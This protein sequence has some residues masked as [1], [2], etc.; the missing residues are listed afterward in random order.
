MQQIAKGTLIPIGGNE[1]KGAGANETET[2]E[3]I[4]E[5][6]LS[7]IVK[8]SGGPEGLFVVIP[9]ASS[10]PLEVGNSYLDAFAK[11][12]CKNV[13]VLDIRN[14]EESEDPKNIEIVKKANCI[15][16]SGGD[17]SK[18]TA[19]IGDTS[20]HSVLMDRYR[21]DS[22]FVIAGTSAGA[23]AMSQEM[24]AGGNPA[25]S[26]TKGAVRMKD[27][28]G[29]T[30]KIMFD[31]HFIQRGRFGRITQAV[32]KYPHILGIGLAENTGLVIKNEETL[33]VIGTGMVIVFDGSEINHNTE[34]DLPDG[35]PMTITN[36]KVQVLANSD[37]YNLV[38][39]EIHVLPID[40]P[41]E[42]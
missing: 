29:L 3:F 1:D 22:D 35:T 38:T 19:K 4:H 7:Q 33:K 26:F 2:L 31:T 40:A 21:N 6:I 17:Q 9:T 25:D 32:A 36:L 42:F 39:K 18:I 23:M 14:K 15:M 10:I 37:I 5:G 24:I 27:G 13:V 8:E 28:L 12:K 20:I 30:P 34:S 11:F 16:F 41:F